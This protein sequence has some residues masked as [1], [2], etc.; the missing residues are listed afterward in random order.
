MV[1]V[2]VSGTQRAQ[3]QEASGRIGFKEKAQVSDVENWDSPE[4]VTLSLGELDVGYGPGLRHDVG[5]D[6]WN[7]GCGPSPKT[8]N[9][10]SSV[11]NMSASDLKPYATPLKAVVAGAVQQFHC[12]SILRIQ[13]KFDPSASQMAVCICHCVRRMGV[14]RKSI[15][16][17]PEASHRA[18]KLPINIF[19]FP[20][21]IQRLNSSGKDGMILYRQKCRL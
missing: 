11:M 12:L 17:A 10:A 2:D 14:T 15:A 13:D 6:I 19:K 20:R 7:E 4:I 8:D 9:C 1:R 5:A 18:I 3:L 21:V 16:I